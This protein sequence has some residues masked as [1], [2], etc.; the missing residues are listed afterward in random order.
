MAIFDDTQPEKKEPSLLL[1]LALLAGLTIVAGGI[2]WGSGLYLSGEAPRPSTAIEPVTAAEEINLAEANDSLGVVQLEPI[3]TNLSGP[4]G[5]WV[6]M[7]MSLVFEGK[8]DIRIA[9]IVQQDILAYLRTVKVYQVEGASGF[10]HL[11]SDLEERAS[12]RSG[13]RVKQLLVRT[14]LFE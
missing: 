13:G 1:Q 7:E 12:I 3:M 8:P 10:Q 2:G 5:T 11:K 14:L 9:Q 6:R 4:S